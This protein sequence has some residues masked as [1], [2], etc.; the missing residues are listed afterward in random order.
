MVKQKRE[1]SLRVPWGSSPYLVVA[2]AYTRG[3]ARSLLKRF[4]GHPLPAG[5]RQRG[6]LVEGRGAEPVRV[7]L[8]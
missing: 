3:E 1:W 4:L 5:L 7:V 8:Q 6:D 2:R